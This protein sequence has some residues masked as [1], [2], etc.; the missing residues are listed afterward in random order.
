MQR[1]ESSPGVGRYF[2]RHCAS[3]LFSR[4]DAMPELL[5]LRIGTL[6]TPLATGTPIAHVFAGSKAEWFAICDSHPQH[7]ERPPG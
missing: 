3:P 6:D 7:A 2:C 4:R 1:F 5:R